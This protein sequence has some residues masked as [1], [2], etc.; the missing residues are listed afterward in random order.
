MRCDDSKCERVLREYD[1]REMEC[2]EKTRKV[3]RNKKGMRGETEGEREE[4]RREEQLR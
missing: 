2:L 1:E 4:K 3:K